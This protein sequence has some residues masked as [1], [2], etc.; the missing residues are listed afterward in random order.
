VEVA[1]GSTARG[2]V[3][4]ALW[5]ASPGAGAAYRGLLKRF[6]RRVPSLLSGVEATLGLGE[7]VLELGT[8]LLF[9]LQ[10]GLRVAAVELRGLSRGALVAEL[11]LCVPRGIA[12]RLGRRARWRPGRAARRSWRANQPPGRVCRCARRPSLRGWLPARRSMRGLRMSASARSRSAPPARSSASSRCCSA[13]VDF[14]R[15][16]HQMSEAE[17]TTRPATR[18]SPEVDAAIVAPQR[19]PR[20]PRGAG[21]ATVGD[22]M[23]VRTRRRVWG[24]SQCA[25]PSVA[26]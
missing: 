25:G 20:Y 21:R 23:R 2:R 8:E 10:R 6:D 7:V 9:A 15:Q 1:V 12:L 14:R 22:E 18:P 24:W 3:K 11:T 13:C 17:C 5:S 26:A 4:L 16:P 19:T